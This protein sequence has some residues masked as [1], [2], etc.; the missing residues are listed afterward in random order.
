MLCSEASLVNSGWDG[1]Q[2][3]SLRCRSWGCPICNEARK[4]QVVALAKSGNPNTFITLTV[5]PA[6]GATPYERAR[7]LADAWR[8]IVRLVKAKYGY[9]ELPYFCVFEATKN[10]EP[11][12]HILCR[13][14]WISQKWLS[15]Q[16]REL[17]MAPV[18]DIRRVRDKSK[19][20][21]YISKYMGKDPHRF[22]TCKRYWTTRDWEQTKFEP[23]PPPGR[24]HSAWRIERTPLAELAEDYRSRGYEVTETRN[25]VLAFKQGP[26]DDEVT[27]ALYALQRR[28]R[29]LSW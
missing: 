5:N 2:A 14:K 13:V 18:V 27:A 20:T 11:H 16:M 7:R 10:G 21:Y 29:G 3:V 22:K 23:E 25:R 28:R 15:E 6:Y 4:K 17:M 8:T 1:Y 12:L 9:A 24:W 26:P 19:L